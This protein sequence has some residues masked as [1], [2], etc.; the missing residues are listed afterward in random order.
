LEEVVVKFVKGVERVEGV[1]AESHTEAAAVPVPIHHNVKSLLIQI[2]RTY[3]QY[4][5]IFT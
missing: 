2:S 1:L 4:K 3:L 5:K